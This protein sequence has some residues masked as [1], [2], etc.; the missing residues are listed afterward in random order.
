MD[1][2]TDAS[3]FPWVRL[4]TG[5]LAGAPGLFCVDADTAPFRVGGR[6]AQVARVCACACPAWPGRT[7]RP[8][9]RILVRLTFSFGRSLFALC[10]F[11]PLR[12]GVA[13]FV[14]VV[15]FFGFLVFLFPFPPLF[16]PSLCPAL[17]VFRLRVPWSLA[18]CPP[19]LFLCPPPILLSLAL[20]AFWLPGASAPPPHLFFSSCVSCFSFFCFFFA[21]C[22]VRGG[23]VCLW[24]S[25]VPVC[26]SV[27]LSLS[28]LT[29]RWL[30]LRGV[31]VGPGCPLLSPGGLWCRASVVLSL[32]GRVARRPVVRRG[33]SWCSAALCCFLLRC[34]VVWW[35]AVVLCGLFASLPAPIVCFLPL[36][37]CCVCSGVSCCVF[38]VLSALCGA[39]LRCAGALLLCCAR[40]LCCFWWL[41]LLVPGVGAFCL[42]SAGGSGCPAL[43]FGGVCR[44]GCPS[45]VWPSLGV[46]PVVSCS[47]VLCHVALCCVVVLCC[48]ALS[49]SF[50]FF[51][52]LVALVSCN[53]P[54]VLGSGPGP[55]RFRFCALPVRCCAGVPAL[56]LSVR[57]SLALAR[58]AGVLCCCLLC[59]CVCC[60]AWLSSVVS[61]WVLVAP[62]VVSRWRA[63][64]CPWVLCCAVLLRIVPPG[65]K[66]LCAVL[67]CFAPF[68]A[69]ARC[70]VSSGAVRCLRVL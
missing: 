37:V 18:S 61:W 23:F 69:A 14:V 45:L 50:F 31:A 68:G 11:G 47:P 6:H 28:L 53:S 26:A 66:L 57:C 10:L 42:G 44:L 19:P 4:A 62:G 46:F 3:G 40:R 24:P 43:S 13:L 38:P 2:V 63:V 39:V 48:G 27:V 70:V 55:G 59:L 20:P 33:V 41:V 9:R 64:A 56:L 29:V 51:S 7:G 8:P 67:F 17:R 54:W 22:A 34:A 58:L 21:G 60:W 16:A 32:S 1:P 36:R 25:G 30:V 65:V 12:A 15:G 52:L 5:D 49:P 35:C